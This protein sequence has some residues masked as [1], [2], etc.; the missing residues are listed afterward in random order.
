MLAA[1][2]NPADLN[3]I[4][5]VYGKRAELPAI[6]GNEGTGVV[7]GLG[8]GVN[9]LSLNDHVIPAN[10][11]LGTWRTAGVF[12]SS[13][14]LK[15][16][17]DIKPEYAATISVN[18]STAYRLLEDF[19]QLKE[20]DVIVQNGANSMVGTAIIQLAKLRGVKTINILR[21]RAD[22]TEVHDRLKALG[23]FIVVSEDYIKTA[24]FKRLISD[25]PQ[26][27]LA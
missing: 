1:P 13:D 16:P 15:V 7:V 2:I 22:F 27:K 14:L 11:G 26:P 10:P 18:P 21:N 9:G 20:G 23:G 4:E 12:K 5:G 8:S 24:Q 19:E 25:L 6:G 3:M 17:S